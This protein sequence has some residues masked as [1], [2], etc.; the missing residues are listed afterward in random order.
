M[1]R[2]RV[3]R[4]S[5]FCPGWDFVVL[6][7]NQCCSH[8]D[9]SKCN[10]GSYRP[11]LGGGGGKGGE[12]YVQKWMLQVRVV[13]TVPY[14]VAGICCLGHCKVKGAHIHCGGEVWE[15]IMCG[16][17]IHMCELLMCGGHIH[18]C[19]LLTCGGDIHM[20]ELI[21]C[22]GDFMCASYSH[23]EGTFVCVSYSC[24][25]GTFTCVS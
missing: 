17:D 9:K 23:V 8:C 16:G 13:T 7:H 21:M 12:S 4:C 5:I 18:M 2:L 22:G 25:E 3:L 10:F 15:L 1:L 14:F 24:V 6:E 19:E 11:L 20:C